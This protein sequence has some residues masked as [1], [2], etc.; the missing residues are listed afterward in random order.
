MKLS[1]EQIKRSTFGAL[2]VKEESDGIHFA[3][4]TEKQ[5]AAWYAL[6]QTLGVRSETTTGIR[7]DFHTNSKTLS[8]TA[9]DGDKF[10]VLI[11]GLQR[12]R[13]HAEAYRAKCEKPTFDLEEGEKRVT[14]IFPSHSRGVLGDVELDDGSYITP[15]KHATKMLFIGDSITQGWNSR[16]DSLSWAWRVTQYYDA[17]SIIQGIGGAYFHEGTWDCVDFDADTV[18]VAYGTNDF[19][20]YS[21]LEE[22]RGHAAKFLDSIF[23]QFG[24]KRVYVISP[25][26]RSDWQKQK[27]MGSFLE[28]CAV[29]KEEAASHG[30]TLIDGME[31]VPYHGD[32]MADAVHP[33]D[34][35]F[36]VYAENVIA[37][38]EK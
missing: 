19:G 34:L 25:I 32:F 30:F 2:S 26:Y 23:A 14:L 8:F 20:H 27:K 3:K 37:K 38:L 6:S 5:V 16:Y 18:L 10:E 21:T 11:N 28:A 33:N 17:D 12:Y 1:F 31:L 35:G 29:V 7:L 15:H 22:M 13:I 36:G 24:D 9:V 4:C